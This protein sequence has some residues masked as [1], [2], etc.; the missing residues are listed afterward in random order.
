MCDGSGTVLL[1]LCVNFV[2]PDGDI[3]L[4][5]WRP[6]RGKTHTSC[7]SKVPDG[8]DNCLALQDSFVVANTIDGIKVFIL[9]LN[10]LSMDNEKL[11]AIE[12]TPP[13]TV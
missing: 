9:V 1:L 11:P 2:L 3:F 10:N 12:I 6:P 7:T 13:G 5:S 4:K 8:G